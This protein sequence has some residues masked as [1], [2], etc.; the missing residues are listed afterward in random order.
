MRRTPLDLI[1]NTVRVEAIHF[2]RPHQRWAYRDPLLRTPLH[3]GPP[4]L[5]HPFPPITAR[6]R[7]INNCNAS[8]AC[9]T[10][11]SSSIVS[12]PNTRTRRARICR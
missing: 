5:P 3:L 6:S 4:L 10:S 2:P 8:P 7:A 12:P 1:H 9:S 11:R